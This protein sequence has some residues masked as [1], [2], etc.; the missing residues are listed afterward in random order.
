MPIP[1]TRRQD[2]GCRCENPVMSFLGQPVAQSGD[3]L[4]QMLRAFFQAEMPN[5]WPSAPEAAPQ[6]VLLP[7]AK[8]GASGLSP[9]TRSRL[10]LAA[11]VALLVAGPLFLAGR[12]D[13]PALPPTTTPFEESSATPLDPRGPKNYKESLLQKPDGTYIQIEFFDAPSK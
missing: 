5:P 8:S 7:A 1:A 10:A 4:D 9:L 3:D 12:Q 11:S 2:Q 13:K 6:P